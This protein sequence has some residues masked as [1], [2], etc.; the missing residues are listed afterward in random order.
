[1]YLRKHLLRRDVSRPRQRNR[2]IIGIKQH[3]HSQEG[4]RTRSYV[5]FIGTSP[6]IIVQAALCALRVVKKV[7]DLMDHFVS[8][9]KNL[10]TDRNHGNLL[11]ATTL[12]SEMVQVDQN[13][14]NEFR[15]VSPSS[16]NN[17][18]IFYL[19]TFARMCR[20]SLC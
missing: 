5:Y 3:V 15:S 18:K 10:L 19:F 2:E 1:M 4:E 11:A 13:C 9:A 20:P 6:Q 8:R 17:T 14:L 12:I 16:L 7:P